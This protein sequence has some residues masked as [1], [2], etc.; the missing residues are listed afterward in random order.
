VTSLPLD[1]EQNEVGDPAKRLARCGRAGAHRAC[2]LGMRS[3]VYLRWDCVSDREYTYKVCE[4]GT[5]ICSKDVV[6]TFP[7]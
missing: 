5:S 6:V 2:T 4:A 1:I 3:I 7:Q